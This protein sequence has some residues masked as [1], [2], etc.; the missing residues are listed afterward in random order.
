M[1]F[2]DILSVK[3]R[4]PKSRD[5]LTILL[6]LLPKVAKAAVSPFPN[7]V[8]E[9]EGRGGGGAEGCSGKLESLLSTSKRGRGLLPPTFPPH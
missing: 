3:E 2:G 8:L 5:V 4:F 6:I 1:V 7:D 9:D